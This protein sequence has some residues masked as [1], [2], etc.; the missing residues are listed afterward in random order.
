VNTKEPTTTDQ[1]R[2]SAVFKSNPI[3]LSQIKCLTPPRRW[4]QTAHREDIKTSL[5]NQLFIIASATWKYREEVAAAK[6]HHT[7]RKTLTI[8]AFPVMRIKIDVIDV[9]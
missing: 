5:P 3:A 7:I 6:S 1:P 8:I 2:Y 9:N 4:Y